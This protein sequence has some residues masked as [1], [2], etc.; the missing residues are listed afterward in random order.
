MLQTVT[1]GKAAPEVNRPLLSDRL[2]EVGSSPGED[3]AS[4][5]TAVP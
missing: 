4:A 3:P 2:L 5:F 1:K